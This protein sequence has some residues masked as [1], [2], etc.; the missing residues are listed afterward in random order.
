MASSLQPVSSRP[1]SLSLPRSYGPGKQVLCK[2]EASSGAEGVENLTLDRGH[3]K[4]TSK[5]PGGRCRVSPP[6]VALGSQ[7]PLLEQR[8]GPS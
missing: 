4:P 2:Q 5:C 3:Q 8:Q 7:R 1:V 6:G